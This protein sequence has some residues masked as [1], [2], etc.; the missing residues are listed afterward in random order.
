MEMANKQA[1]IYKD[2]RKIAAIL[3]AGSVSRGCSDEHSDIELHIFWN[4]PIT[5]ADRLGVIKRCNGEIIDF[6]PYEEEEWSESYKVGEIKFEIS[7]FLVSTIENWCN[8]LL[9]HS[10]S[11]EDKQCVVS[12][13]VDG[14]PIYGSELICTWK[15]TLK[16]FPDELKELIIIENFTFS[17]RWKHRYALLER[18]DFLVLYDAVIEVE[19][20][21]MKIL[22]ALNGMYVQNPKFKWLKNSLNQMEV[23]PRD[24]YERLTFIL[25]NAYLENGIKELEKLVAEVKSLTNH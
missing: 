20:K 14:I 2:N 16:N 3:I 6:H 7:H 12:S 13:V 11:N 1:D 17:G 24:C 21:L 9:I 5:D 18:E 4:E 8:D 25:K 19:K 15:E 10:D 23:K 22:F